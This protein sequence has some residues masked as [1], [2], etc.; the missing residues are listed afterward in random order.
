MEGLNIEKHLAL[1]KLWNLGVKEEVIK[2]Y[3][4]L[5][6]PENIDQDG[7]LYDAQNSITLSKLLKSEGI[8]CANS[9][10]LGLNLP[11]TER[12]SND[13]WLGQLYIL[14]DIILPTVIGVVTG[15]IGPLILD[16]KN[17]KDLREP[18]GNVHADITLI[19]PEGKT[20]IHYNGEPEALVKI[21]EALKKES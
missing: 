5:I 16:W 12:R 2:D 20:E 3:D 7:E 1:Q 4:I 9:Y 19:R 17:R 18:A 13:I 6:L 8:K 15:V 14:N 21:I 11:T 10:D